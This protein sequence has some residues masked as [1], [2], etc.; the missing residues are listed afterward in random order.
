MAQVGT[1]GPGGDRRLPLQLEARRSLARLLLRVRR[2]EHRKGRILVGLACFA[3]VSGCFG[4]PPVSSPPPNA[5]ISVAIGTL[6]LPTRVECEGPAEELALL[7]DICGA[8]TGTLA[9]RETTGGGFRVV[10]GGSTGPYLLIYADPSDEAGTFAERLQ[11]AAFVQMEVDDE[12]RPKP[13]R[14]AEPV[15]EG[16]VITEYAE[17]GYAGYEWWRA[18][19]EFLWRHTT[20]R[21]AWRAHVP[22]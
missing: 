17:P 18:Q 20:I 3:G 14:E 10:V 8:A 7:G 19:G 21:L 1:G 2:M 13:W 16:V 11:Y 12:G 6:T 15:A 9:L 22:A 4:P 5:S